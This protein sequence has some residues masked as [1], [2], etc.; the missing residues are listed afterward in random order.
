MHYGPEAWFRE[1][2]RARR[3]AAALAAVAGLPLLGLLLA[4]RYTPLR[5]TV[6][7]LDENLRFGLEGERERYVRRIILESGRGLAP[8]PVTIGAYEERSER[9]GGAA[10]APRRDVERGTVE[11]REARG[12]EG[13]GDAFQNLRA[14]ALAR[15]S[16]VPIVE[17][18]QLVVERLVRPVYPELAREANLTGR[19]AVLALVD[20]TGAIAEVDVVGGSGLEVLERAAV[21][22]VW[23]C[24]FR[25]YRQ[26]GR[27]REVY[28]VIPFNFTLY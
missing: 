27:A 5:G 4:L 10:E 13:E 2:A 21:E 15:R 24:R 7:R 20:T 6:E 9:R 8:E 11:T 17:S 12:L 26:E 23:Q 28:V 18:D 25:P 22:A 14:R 19:V 16:D 3:R 1:S